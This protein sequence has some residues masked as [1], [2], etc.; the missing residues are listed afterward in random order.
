M[1]GDSEGAADCVR[2]ALHSVSGSVGQWVNGSDIDLLS[3]F[4]SVINLDTELA[5]RALDHSVPERLGFILRI[6]FLIEN[7]RSVGCRLVLAVAT[8]SRVGQ[9]PP[10]RLP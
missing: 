8:C 9:M 1:V 4:D 6:S 5:H 10:D 2:F 7:Q 3:D